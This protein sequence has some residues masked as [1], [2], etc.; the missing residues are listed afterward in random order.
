M[1]MS[2][3]NRNAALCSVVSYSMASC[4]HLDASYCCR[5]NDHFVVGPC[6]G[7]HALSIFLGHTLSDHSNEHVLWH[8]QGPP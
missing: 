7:N 5:T 1:L 6:I 4:S 2:F 8:T 3:L